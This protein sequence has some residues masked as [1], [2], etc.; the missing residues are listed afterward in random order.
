MPVKASRDL[1]SEGQIGASR[2]PVAPSMIEYSAAMSRAGVSTS[3][4]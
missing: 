2:W 3:C 1:P 4:S